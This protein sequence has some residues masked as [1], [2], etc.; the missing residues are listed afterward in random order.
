MSATTTAI[1]VMVI[2]T[3]GTTMRAPLLPAICYL[4]GRARGLCQL[5]DRARR[6]CVEQ[7]LGDELEVLGR[8]PALIG[9]AARVEDRAAADQHVDV[10]AGHLARVGQAD[11]AVHADQHVGSGL[12]GELADGRDPAAGAGHG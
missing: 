12:G 5:P 6:L 10:P 1:W 3:G 7:R 8:A 2:G 9:G 11:P 4:L